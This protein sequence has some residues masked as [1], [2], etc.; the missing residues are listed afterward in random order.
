M[1]AWWIR[2]WNPLVLR[3]EGTLDV[4]K[5]QSGG[6]E[7]KKLFAKPVDTSRPYE[8]P[9]V[10]SC[11]LKYCRRLLHEMRACHSS[12]GLPDRGQDNWTAIIISICTLMDVHWGYY[13][14]MDSSMLTSTLTTPR[15]ILLGFLSAMNFS[16]TPCMWHEERFDGIAIS[17]SRIPMTC[18]NWIPGSFW[19]MTKSRGG[20]ETR[21][22]KHP[23]GVCD[24]VEKAWDGQHRCKMAL[25]HR[26]FTGYE[27]KPL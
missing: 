14:G 13:D 15:L 20:W 4:R 12:L 26:Y 18:Q 8:W 23:G 24:G 6:R 5:P 19:H 3:W 21:S 10:T 11:T 17:R 1:P 25:W 16:V 2:R 27:Q 22:R 7:G 9:R